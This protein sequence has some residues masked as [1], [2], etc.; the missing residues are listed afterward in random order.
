MEG[1]TSSTILEASVV[2]TKIGS[3]WGSA[4]EG[5]VDADLNAWDNSS[6]PRAGW[7]AMVDNYKERIR[8]RDWISFW[9]EDE[10]FYLSSRW[11]RSAKSFPSNGFLG[12]PLGRLALWRLIH[13]DCGGSMSFHQLLQWRCS[14]SYSWNWA[15]W[16][17][18]YR[19]PLPVQAWGIE[20]DV[21]KRFVRIV[22]GG[23]HWMNFLKKGW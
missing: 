6:A 16:L 8:I 10:L 23:I 3:F 1:L 17:I 7:D 18:I 20:F 12:C 13:Y 4:N 2:S 22:G 21:L 15:W 14:W 9:E 19:M 11:S 5:L